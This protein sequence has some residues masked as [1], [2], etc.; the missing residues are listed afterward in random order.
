MPGYRRPFVPGA[1]VFFTVNLETRGAHLLI[2]EV[3]RLREAVRHVR[4]A[5]PFGIDAWVVLPDHMHA[6]WTLPEGDADVA[7]RWAAIKSRFSCGLPDGPR[8]ASHVARREK[9]V[10]QRRFWGEERPENN[11]VDRSQ[12]R[13]GGAQAAKPT[14]CG[15]R[16]S[17]RRASATADSTQSS[18]AWSSAL[19]TGRFRPSTGTDP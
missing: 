1:T 6:V 13:T 8:R 11:P 17:G 19:R 16:R 4:A 2:E 7:T 14:T 10:W 3:D 18:T 5:R 9:G 12:R 15:A